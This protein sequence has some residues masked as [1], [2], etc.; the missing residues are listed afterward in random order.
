MQ[1]VL[2]EKKNQTKVLHF[3][4]NCDGRQVDDKRKMQNKKLILGKNKS[5]FFFS[6]KFNERKFETT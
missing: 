1:V 3:V 4:S 2:N 5:I 6:N